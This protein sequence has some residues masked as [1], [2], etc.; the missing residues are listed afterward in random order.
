M[1]V[2]VRRA[3]VAFIND[4]TSL[5]VAEADED[6]TGAP[7]LGTSSADGLLRVESPMVG[8]FRAPNP[9]APAFVDVGDTVIPGQT[10]CLLEAMKL[11]NELNAE[12]ILV[13][14]CVHTENGQ[15]VE[16]VQLLFEIEP[17]L[18]PPAV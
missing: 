17:I 10:L 16:F 3:D 9:G 5:A 2:S 1:R 12:S 6:G 4:T 7:E 15:P 8:V 11:F 13:R 18:E 14:R